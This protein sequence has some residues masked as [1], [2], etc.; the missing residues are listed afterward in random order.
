[1][2][3]SPIIHVY[4]LF[5]LVLSWR[6]GLKNAVGVEMA[7]DVGSVTVLEQLF[8]FALC[9]V[10]GRILSLVLGCLMCNCCWFGRV[11]FCYLMCICC[12]VCV[13][14]FLLYMPDC[15]L[16]VSI[17]KVLRP[18]TSTQVFLGFPVSISKC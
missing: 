3:D 16:E 5:E 18:A 15:W 12:T 14:L 7:R 1:V 11:Y 6:R 2:S 17:R 4:I 9:S 8:V 10:A 13:L